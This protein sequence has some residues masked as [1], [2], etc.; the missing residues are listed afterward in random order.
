M[1]QRAAGVI[2]DPLLL[3]EV[4]AEGGKKAIRVKMGASFA[5][6][7]S[8]AVGRPQIA[9]TVFWSPKGKSYAHFTRVGEW[10]S[11]FARPALEKF[12]HRF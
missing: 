2:S 12:Q 3:R 5:F 1:A 4:P 7:R 11:G 8:K 10:L 9:R 6:H